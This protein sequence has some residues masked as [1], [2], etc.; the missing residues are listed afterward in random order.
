M[1]ISVATDASCATT[2]A[3]VPS[4]DTDA[5]VRSPCLVAEVPALLSVNAGVADSGTGVLVPEF[6]GVL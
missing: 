3:T 6:A 4:C 5:S 2:S 1:P